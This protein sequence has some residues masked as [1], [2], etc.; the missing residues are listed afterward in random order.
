MYGEKTYIDKYIFRTVFDRIDLGDPV[1]LYWIFCTLSYLRNS[2]YLNSLHPNFSYMP[3]NLNV[4]CQLPLTLSSGSVFYFRS[5]V[6][7]PSY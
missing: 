2:I 3:K 7:F 1:L 6:R 4:N 5:T